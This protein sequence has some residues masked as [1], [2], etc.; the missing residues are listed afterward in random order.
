[1]ADELALR[2]VGRAL[3]TPPVRA[4]K[5]VEEGAHAATG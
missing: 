2:L 3:V 5:S 1:V 4:A